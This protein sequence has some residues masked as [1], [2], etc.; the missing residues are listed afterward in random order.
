MPKKERVWSVR[1]GLNVVFLIRINFVP[2]CTLIPFRSC[3]VQRADSCSWNW[4]IAIQKVTNIIRTLLAQT[5]FCFVGVCS[6]LNEG[7]R[8]QFINEWKR[9]LSFVENLLFRCAKPKFSKLLFWNVRKVCYRLIINMQNSLAAAKY[10]NK[11]Q[12]FHLSV[13]ARMRPGKMYFRAM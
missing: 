9:D 8:K 13:S 5:A 3:A 4:W 2:A 6:R 12:H 1:E 10:I 11:F 7:E